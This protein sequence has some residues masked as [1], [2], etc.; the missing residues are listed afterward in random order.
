[1]LCH[2]LKLINQKKKKCKELNDNENLILIIRKIFFR[3]L[4]EIVRNDSSQSLRV[5]LNWN[6]W[7]NFSS[8]FKDKVNLYR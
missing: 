3:E 1:M 7:L 5:F 8:S 6:Y 2:G 4:S